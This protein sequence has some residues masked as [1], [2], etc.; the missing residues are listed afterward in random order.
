MNRVGTVDRMAQG[1]LIARSHDRTTPAVGD[2]VVDEALEGIGRVV[3]VIGPVDRPY[4][5]IDPTVDDAAGLLNRRVYV[6]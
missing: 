4:V 2:T 3:D 6:R 5:V 1:L